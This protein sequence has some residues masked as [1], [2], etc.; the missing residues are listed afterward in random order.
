MDV[1]YRLIE[2]M[3]WICGSSSGNSL[4]E[5]LVAK[6]VTTELEGCFYMYEVN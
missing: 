4:E 5:R 2:R 6:A 3:H 1:M